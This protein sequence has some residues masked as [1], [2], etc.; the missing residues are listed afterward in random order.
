MRRATANALLPKGDAVT[1]RTA[2]RDC[3]T[4]VRSGKR[5][6]SMRPLGSPL[7]TSVLAL[8]LVTLQVMTHADHSPPIQVSIHTPWAAP[9]LLL[10][11]LEAVAVE[12]RTS[13]YPLMR[14]LTSP[15]FLKTVS[16]PQDLYGKSLE[17]IQSQGHLHRQAISSLKWSLAMHTTAPWIEAHYHLYNSTIVPDRASKG[18]FDPNCNVWVDWYDHQVC[19]ASELEAIVAKGLDQ[20]S[21]KAS[22][23][24]TTMDLDHVQ[25]SRNDPSL[26][27]I[28]YADVYDGEFTKFRKYLDTL[29]IEHGLQY[30]IRYRPSVTNASE[31]PLSLAGYGVEL[32]L[33]NT[34]YIVIDDRDLGHN[35]DDSAF[36]QTVFSAD[37]EQILFEGEGPPSVEPVSEQDLPSLDQLTAQ[38]VLQSEDPLKALV[39]VSQ[40]FPKYQRKLSKITLNETLSRAFYKNMETASGQNSPKIWLNNQPVPHHKMN[41]FN[42]IRLLRRERDAIGS[43][44]TIGVSTKKAVDLLTDFTSAAKGDSGAEVPTG[45]FDVRD[46]SEEKD[47]IVWLNDLEKDQRYRGWPG[48]E[49]LYR[50]LYHG[51]FHQIRKNIIN[52]LLVLDLSSPRSL[53]VIGFEIF[54][55]IQR[56]VPFRFGVLP[57]VKSDNGEDV[58]MAMLW[59]HLVSRHGVR[60]GI[61]FVKQTII[62]HVQAGDDIPS[63]ARKAFEASSKLPKL[64]TSETPELMYD[65]VIAPDSI[66]RVWLKSVRAMEEQIGITAPS[67]FVNGKFFA[68]HEDHSQHLMSQA[69]R[70][71]GFLISR[72]M[73]G[74]LNDS[75]DVY[76]YLLTLPG[77]HPR[78]NPYV[79]VSDDAPPKIIDLVQGQKSPFVDSLSYFTADGSTD[80]ALTLHIAADFDSKQGLAIGL[81]ALSALE[82]NEYPVRLAFIQNGQYSEE[83]LPSL[84]NFVRQ[85]CIDRKILP[86]G[87]WRTLLQGINDGQPFSESFVIASGDHPEIA[88]IA[89]EGTKGLE[90]QSDRARHLFLKDTLKANEGEAYII[91]NGR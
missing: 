60:G 55:F 72:L 14:Q 10:E 4:D 90:E 1:F 7:R 75:V 46:K 30:S 70:Q 37:T 36:G 67:H 26:F 39:A 69:P 71:T 15:D 9:P 79:F 57:L 66:Y 16:S 13:Y 89:F 76:E 80:Q 63:A 32:A 50:P 5:K 28:L 52:S 8:A 49:A 2:N 59:R 42:L 83:T 25:S 85:S 91:A 22:S 65:E 23:K 20:Y 74:E 68:W 82:A 86:L 11:I 41:P 33:K 3:P 40:D 24:P 6:V 88:A 18:G 51:Q 77:V 56:M 62:L 54:N 58:K 87:F 61:E 43:F 48:L 19:T 45:V 31:R 21:K 17:I 34:D 35:D 44:A 29:A 53:E 81:A 38:F 73:Q 12:N 47:L 84:A 27:T 64:K 78:R